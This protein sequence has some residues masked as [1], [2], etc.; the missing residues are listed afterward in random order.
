M[1]HRQKGTQVNHTIRSARSLLR[2]DLASVGAS[3]VGG[4]GSGARSTS[5]A[6]SAPGLARYSSPEISRQPSRVRERL[7]GGGT[8]VLKLSGL[9]ALTIAALLALVASSASAATT[10]QLQA[11]ITEADSAAPPAE[12]GSEGPG[13]GQISNER[14]ANVR[15]WLAGAERIR[16]RLLAHLRLTGIAVDQES[17]DL[18][19]ADR[20]N[21]RIDKFGFL[22][23]FLRA[24]LPGFRTG[25]SL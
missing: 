10:H 16:L 9:L 1:N 23:N 12:F 24:F 21:S 5:R 13:A 19:V 25:A 20:N 4:G 11:Q 18:Y 6:S 8:A 17:H 7:G 3:E 2:R 15:L 22:V 14:L